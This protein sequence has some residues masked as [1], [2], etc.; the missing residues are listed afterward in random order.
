MQPNKSNIDY[1][2]KVTGTTMF[3]SGMF[4][5]NNDFKPMG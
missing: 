2:E 3:G 4:G 1:K 5:T